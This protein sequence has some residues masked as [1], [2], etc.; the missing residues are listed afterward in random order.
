MRIEF[1]YTPHRYWRNYGLPW[2]FKCW[3][4][5]WRETHGFQCFGVRVFGCCI[6]VH[7]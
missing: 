6:E 3:A 7:P 1:Y 4:F 5:R 2:F